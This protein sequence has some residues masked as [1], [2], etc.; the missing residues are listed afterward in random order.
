MDG[1]FSIWHW[2]SVLVYLVIFLVPGWRISRKAGFHR[3]W[4]LLLLIPFVNL[5]T[6]WIFA[7]IRW[8]NANESV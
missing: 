1:G 5:I 3:A 6:I 8:P 2:L 7:F 4:C